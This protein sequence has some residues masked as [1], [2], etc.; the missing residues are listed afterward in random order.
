MFTNLTPLIP[1]SLLRRGGKIIIGGASPL[2]STLN[3]L[4]GSEVVIRGVL[5]GR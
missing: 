5:E 4:P 1:L 2:Q 3:K